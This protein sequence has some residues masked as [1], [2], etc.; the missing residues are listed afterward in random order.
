[1]ATVM[2]NLM[3]IPR[4][5]NCYK[6]ASKRKVA[7]D[8]GE[9]KPKQIKRDDCDS[10]LS[11]YKAAP[12]VVTPKTHKNTLKTP[13]TTPISTKRDRATP[14]GTRKGMVGKKLQFDEFAVETD[15]NVRIDDLCVQEE[16]YKRRPARYSHMNK[17]VL[18]LIKRP[19]K[20]SG[21]S[22]DHFVH[23]SV[24]TAVL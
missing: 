11:L 16:W 6:Q 22:R 8:E 18:M 1:M 19:G 2:A 17:K 14:T 21:K 3:E 9:P 20:G 15:D 12:K 13:R 4:K 7:D 10:K 24:H 5:N 23:I